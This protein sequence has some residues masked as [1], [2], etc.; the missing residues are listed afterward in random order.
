MIVHTEDIHLF[1]G[2]LE[3]P[4]SSRYLYR[5]TS[6]T[7]PGYKETDQINDLLEEIKE[8]DISKYFKVS[9]NKYPDSGDIFVNDIFMSKIRYSIVLEIY[10]KPWAT[11][12]QFATSDQINIE[13]YRP[14]DMD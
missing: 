13:F 7:L 6:I 2:K 5:L 14:L 10:V 12:E 3:K 8:A 9:F 1:L 4:R 11:I